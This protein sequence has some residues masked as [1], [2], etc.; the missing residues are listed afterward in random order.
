MGKIKIPYN[1]DAFLVSVTWD[2]SQYHLIKA[3]HMCI[4]GHV[5]K[6]RKGI[7]VQEVTQPVSP[8]HIHCPLSPKAS[9]SSYSPS[10]LPRSTWGAA[11]P[12]LETLAILWFSFSSFHFIIVLFL[13]TSVVPGVWV[14]GDFFSFELWIFHFWKMFCNSAL[15]IHQW[16]KKVLCFLLCLVYISAK[17]CGI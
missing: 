13:L 5:L 9:N 4:H 10:M 1:S 16:I 6:H 14:R 11:S 17:Q 12:A 8:N 3:N 15:P 7:D 2:I